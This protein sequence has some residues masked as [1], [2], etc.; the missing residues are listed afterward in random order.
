VRPHW[1][2]TTVGDHG[3]LRL[4]GL[5]F[6]PGQA[7]EVLVLPKGVGLKSAGNDSLMGSVL[8]YREPF[9]PVADEDWDAPR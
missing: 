6:D 4:E 1:I 3:E 2:E 5:P 9:E 8:E 7:V